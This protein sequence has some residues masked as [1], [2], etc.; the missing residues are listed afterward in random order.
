MEPAEGRRGRL[1]VTTTGLMDPQLIIPV[2]GDTRAKNL[3]VMMGKFAH[4][5][6]QEPH[7]AVHLSPASRYGRRRETLQLGKPARGQQG[8]AVF[9]SIA[10]KSTYTAISPSSITATIIAWRSAIATSTAPLPLSKALK[11]SG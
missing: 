5:E 1:L 11:A 4:E 7:V 6:E 8:D 10:Q 9:T 2:D 3:R